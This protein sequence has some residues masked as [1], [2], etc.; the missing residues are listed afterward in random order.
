MALQNNDWVD[1][2]QE[3]VTEY[4][5]WYLIFSAAAYR[6]AHAD[7]LRLTERTFNVTN[8]LRGLNAPLLWR[9]PEIIRGLRMTS[10]P[11]WA[12]D[13]L[14]GIS[15]AGEGLIRALENDSTGRRRETTNTPQLVTI[16]GT[17]ERGYDHDLLPWLGEERDPTDVELERA[18]QIIA[19]RLALSVANPV[20]RNEQEAR[21]LRGL[22]RWLTEREYQESENQEGPYY[23]MAPGT[24]RI[25]VDAEGRRDNGN[26]VKVPVDIVIMP[27]GAQPGDLPILMECKS[28]GD[29]TNVNKRRKEE[30]DKHRNLV[31][32]HGED[33]RYVLFLSGY[34][35]AN[36]LN[37]ERDA[38][39][40]WFWHHRINDIAQLRL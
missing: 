17:L 7:A 13:R 36:Y 25:H 19:D 9:N 30:S 32:R 1:D 12:V 23:M 29:F 18:K 34:F 14:I 11:P 6:E 10:S 16:I 24:Y 4:N 15:G 40:Q 3:S 28:A 26:Q 20:I 22:Q 2:T 35:G 31:N 37:Y 39:I 21:Q 27:M 5:A 8:N 38:G 33:V